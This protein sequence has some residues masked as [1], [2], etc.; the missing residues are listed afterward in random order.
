M[1][2]TSRPGVVA[3]LRALLADRRVSIVVR[4]GGYLLIFGGFLLALQG[5]LIEGLWLVLLGWLLT[6]AARGSYNAGRLAAL[7]DGLTVRDALDA[8]PPSVAPSLSL[9]TLVEEDG[10][11]TG[12]S[13]VYPVRAGDALVGVFDVLD[14]DA[15]PR[16][17]WA[18][19]PISAVQQPLGALATVPPDE[20]LLDTVARFERSR[21]EAFAVVDPSEPGQLLGLVTRERVH[22]LMR[23]R[24]SRMQPSRRGIRR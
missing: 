14:A 13:G 6:R 3:R 9:E 2:S 12:G 15:V 17:D 20:P 8:D 22:A 16:A 24:A 1:T 18:T 4:S 5:T 7:L 23:S 19:T 21:R 11:Q 10:R